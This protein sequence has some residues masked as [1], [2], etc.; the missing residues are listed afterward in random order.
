MNGPNKLACYT[1]EGEKSFII[2]TLGA[3]PVQHQLPLPALPSAFQVTGLPIP[4]NMGPF[5][6]YE[7]NSVVNT[8]PLGPT[9]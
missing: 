9:I 3:G 7:E 1:A 2:L 6:S 5:L 8:V 4:W